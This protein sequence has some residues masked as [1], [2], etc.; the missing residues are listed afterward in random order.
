MNLLEKVLEL[1]FAYLETF[2]KRIKKPWGSLYYN[3]DQPTYYDANHA[4]IHE[5][6]LD[7]KA[8]IEEVVAFYNEKGIIPRFYLYDMDNQ[9]N[10]IKELQSSH[11]QIEAFVSPIQLWNKEIIES[12]KNDRVTVEKV[13]EDNFREAFE[14]ECSMTEFGGREVR[15]AAFIEEYKHP[16]FTHYLLRYD[17][18]ACSTACLF[19][20]QDQMRME[21]VA[22]KKE[23]RGKGL[24]GELIRFIQLEV[25][26]RGFEHLWVFPINEQIEQVYAKYG[27]ETIGK[28]KTGHAFLS[29]KSLKDIREGS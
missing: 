5:I 6:L 7:P 23:F 27:F 25:K 14:V 9:A 21:S 11:F 4:H 10:L 24:I 20:H 12:E 13:T 17:G 18:V 3:E 29:G 26:N 19:E 16:S 22:T 1:D 8:V 2:T 28:M 15:G